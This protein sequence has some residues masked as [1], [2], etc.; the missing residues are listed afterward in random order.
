YDP[1]TD[2]VMDE[3]K[4][5]KQNNALA[6]MLQKLEHMNIGI[7]TY[8]E[9]GWE[10]RKYMYHALSNPSGQDLGHALIVLDETNIKENV[11]IGMDK[12]TIMTSQFTKM[13]ILYSRWEMLEEINTLF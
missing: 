2:I 10:E 4:V 3:P 12:Q 6:Q 5:P 7:I 8:K 13:A 1:F 9:L 11:S